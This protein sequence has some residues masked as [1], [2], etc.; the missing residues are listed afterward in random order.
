MQIQNEHHSFTGMQ[1]DLSPSKHPTSFLYDAKNIRLTSREG[2]TM[3]AITNEKGTS[4]T[5]ISLVGNYL[6]HCLLNEYLVVFT[7]SDTLDYIY[8]IDLQKEICETLY[9][10]SKLGFDSNH[11]IE[12]IASYENSKVQKVYWVDGKNQPRLIN[13]VADTTNYNSTSFD[14]IT[15]L[16]LEEEVS[17][18]K[19]FGMG[20]FP[21]GV[22]QYA[23]TYFNKHLQES[24][25]FYVTPLQYISF[26]DRAGNP[27]EK[28][29]NAFKLTINNAESNKF[30]YLRIYSIL[31]TSLNG[32]P[33][34]KRIQDIPLDS[35]VKGPIT[36]IDDGLKGD[37]IDPTELLYK[38][39]EV[40]KSKSITQKDN[41]LFLGNISISREHPNIAESILTYTGITD[42]NNIANENLST[43][44]I[45][46]LFSLN[47]PLNF[48]DH[49][50][51]KYVYSP[52]YLQNLE[53]R[54]PF[55]KSREYYR[56]GIQFQH[57]SGKW[58]EPYWIG[59]KQCNY[60]PKLTYNISNSHTCYI[61]VGEFEFNLKDE[62]IIEELISSGY[63]KA[64]GL[65]AI[66]NMQDR[67]ILCQGICCPTLKKESSEY[68]QPSWIFRYNHGVEGY[69]DGD[70]KVGIK[71]GGNI[72]FEGKL[73]SHYDNVRIT[74][75]TNS[76]S[77]INSPYIFST[78]VMGKYKNEDSYNVEHSLSTL[79][80]PD[81]L[82]DDSFYSLDFTNCSIQEVGKISIKHTYG[83]IDIQ[84]STPPIGSSSKGFD[85]SLIKIYN[86]SLISGNFYRDYVVDDID[87]TPKYGSYEKLSNE[88]FI[89]P[90]YMWH[91]NGSLNNDVNREGR[92]AELLKK[93]IS[94][95]IVSDTSTY[96][97]GSSITKHKAKD[98]KLFKDDSLSL[99]KVN[100]KNYMGNIDTMLTPEPSPYYV[101]YPDSGYRPYAV[102]T[103]DLIESN[104]PETPGIWELNSD[105]DTYHAISDQIGDHVK[106]LCVW[107]EGVSI[108]YKS[109][110]HLII[111]YEDSFPKSQEIATIPIL[112]VVKPYNK[113]VMY[114]GVTKDAMYNA[115]WIPCGPTVAIKNEGF[116]VEYK[117]G[118]TYM[119]RH[120]CLKTYPFTQE[121]KNQ[122]IEIISFLC[123]TRIN[124]SGRYDRNKGNISNLN[125]SPI[126]FN[127]FNPVYNQLDN[128][129]SYRILE[130]SYYTTQNFPNQITWSKEKQS[131][132]EID[133][134]TNLTLASTYD[135]DGSK[136]K[137]VSLKTYNNSIFCFQDRGISNILFNSRV[138]I[139]TSDSI[140]IEISNSYKL[141][142]HRYIAEGMGCDNKHKIKDTPSGIYF[143]D[144]LS[145][146]LFNIGS[147]TV[148]ITTTKNMSS[149]FKSNGTS[150][151][152][153]VYDNTH[154][155][156]YLITDSTALCFSEVLGQ[157]TSFMDY[158]N[159]QLMESYGT[160]VF[161][162]HTNTSLYKLFSGDYNYFFDSYK[163]WG[164]TFI[165]NGVD[166]SLSDFDKIFSNIDY[167]LD[168]K[169]L[170]EYKHDKSL[171]YIRV[172]NEYQDTGEVALVNRKLIDNKVTYSSSNTNLKKKFRVWRIQIPRD[173]TH[174]MDRI[175]N[176][177]CKITLGNNG[178][179]NSQSVLHD[180]NVQYY[181]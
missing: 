58:T 16:S 4:D 37:N 90:I 118:D 34:V 91:K 104:R 55:F 121:D 85:H 71:G 78:E 179:T 123:E 7:T 14:F 165:S 65:Y 171:D 13:I 153:L 141:D 172:E 41:T 128:F 134:Y 143:I 97:E 108:K 107:R 12:A 68:Y 122:V 72:T 57:E 103:W 129:F 46:R 43:S 95:Y 74:S 120:E 3:F 44:S 9:N 149:W 178:N 11:P 161:V 67:T 40:I 26:I 73:K 132:A 69:D 169:E 52:N 136:G 6:G 89:W 166:N 66:P 62:D 164:F 82:F 147:E 84:T 159:V 81:L 31:R 96:Y 146:K 64:R 115:T 17:I 114:G 70:Y 48:S 86:G 47:S 80:S 59:D 63:K 170:G 142:G 49:L 110:P 124:I 50:D 8:R 177:W 60:T 101:F 102:S 125:V 173:E 29:A 39:G 88:P 98:I 10:K 32:V 56:L 157:F 23:F 154:N 45:R 99:L 131:G 140:P 151:N 35:N 116:T 28:I 119:Q 51:T 25:I 21:P 130:D 54:A 158:N 106:N 30:E 42:T 27:E 24:S 137:I 168:I 76:T 150:I 87:N 36:F 152:K 5:N 15:T 156:L 38:G 94:N 148:D 180:L 174:K 155:D 20:E 100:G 109:T 75:K 138:Q 1:R 92:S 160:N 77:K 83:D 163:P 2:D 18:K 127:L 139:P 117:W 176:T 126:N 133:A 162:L 144:T 181:V 33:I 145:N 79:H 135:L 61:N 112:E 105:T 93:K 175:R 22:I 167:R 111:D 19:L 113:D 53:D